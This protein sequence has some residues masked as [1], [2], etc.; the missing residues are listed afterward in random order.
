[1]PLVRALVKA[2]RHDVLLEPLV[3]DEP[4]HCDGFGY[5]L[6][7]PSSL[8][9]VK[10]DAADQLGVCREACESNL[11]ALEEAAGEVCR[12]LERVGGNG[13]WA[14]LVMHA[15]R[16]GSGEPRGSVHAHPYIVTCL[17]R[18]GS[19][20]YF[21]V[22]NG[23]VDKNAIASRLL[24]ASINASLV[25]DSNVL[26]EALLRGWG[27]SSLSEF[28]RRF[29]ALLGYVKTALITAT[30]A[31]GVEGACIIATSYVREDLS[32]EKRR[33]YETY[34]VRSNGLA[35]IASSTVSK[36]LEEM[37]LEL[38]RKLLSGIEVLTVHHRV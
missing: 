5:V 33:Y 32:L 28:K 12:E 20:Q 36:Y 35:A 11:H 15:R 26:A 30:L 21:L 4:E 7:T 6:Y 18:N 25:T 13:F 1:M 16:A 2:A 37:G 17:G 3:A 10:H 38:D 27:R 23:G 19:K 9:I 14:Y 31:V 29:Q 24:R 8:V 22:H 34:L